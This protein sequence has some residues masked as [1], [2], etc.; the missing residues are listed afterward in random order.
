M[1]KDPIIEPFITLNVLVTQDLDE[2]STGKTWYAQGMEID[3]LAQG[4]DLDG[5]IASFE[6]GLLL[7][8]KAH[9]EKR[10]HIEGLL[11]PATGDPGNGEPGWWRQYF[12][13]QATHYKHSWISRRALAEKYSTPSTMAE[14]YGTESLDQLPI[15][16]I[17][18]IVPWETK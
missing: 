7:T 1:N 10:G 5:V 2:D 11:R 13:A 8:V 6:Q 16:G 12:A 9:I 3:Y 15:A 17:A 4:A 18:Y 14:R